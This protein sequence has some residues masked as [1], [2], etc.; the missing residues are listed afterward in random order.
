MRRPAAVAVAVAAAA[1]LAACGPTHSVASDVR[2]WASVNQVGTALGDLVTDS[3]REV[4]AIDGHASVSQVRT[5]CQESL[6]DEMGVYSSILPSP[7]NKLTNLLT[8]AIDGFIHLADRCVGA[9]GDRAVLDSVVHERFLAIGVLHEAVLREEAIAG[10]T[11]H[12]AGPT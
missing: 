4:A 8:N 11:L 6:T 12:V 3:Q 1:C 5:V 9:P 10:Q 7:D 2:S